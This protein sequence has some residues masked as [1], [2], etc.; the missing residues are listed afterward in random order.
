MRIIIGL[1]LSLCL[2]CAY[3]QQALNI[4][5]SNGES[6][7]LEAISEAAK[8]KQFVFVGELHGEAPAHQLELELLQQLY[9]K[10]G[11]KLFLGMEMFE[12]DVQPIINEYWQ[13]HINTRSFESE[14]RVWNNYADYRPLV[15]FAKAHQIPL[16]ATNV[17]RR[18]ANAVYHQGVGILDSLSDY[19]KNL[20]PSLPMEVDSTL[21]SYRELKNM[22]PGHGGE[23]MLQSQ[24]LKDAS[25]AHQILAHTKGDQI[26]L[27]LNGVYH[28]KNREGIISFMKSVHPD[29]MLTITSITKEATDHD[30]KEA[31]FTL[32]I[33]AKTD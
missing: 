9:A 10:H 4:R 12:T 13:G 26:I 19:A 31:D 2:H 22:I 29:K 16:V 21:A 14:A 5:N 32:L 24:A 27:H 1:L 15:E 6:V 17:P 18:Y 11:D 28:T 8:G 25:M 7:T 20:L 30:F 23:N 33:P 3:A